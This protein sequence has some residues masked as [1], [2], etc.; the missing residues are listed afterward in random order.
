MNDFVGRKWTLMSSA[1]FMSLS[2]VCFA[3]GSSVGV[4]IVG[5]FLQVIELVKN[6]EQKEFDLKSMNSMIYS[7]VLSAFILFFF[8]RA[9]VLA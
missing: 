5:R 7:N 4:I 9:A 3:L 1:F 8:L 2:Y 6:F